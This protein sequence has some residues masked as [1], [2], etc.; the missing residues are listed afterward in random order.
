MSA[1]IDDTTTDFARLLRLVE[2]A[3][4]HAYLKHGG[5]IPREDFRE[6]GLHGLTRALEKTRQPDALGAYAAAFIKGEI[7]H[8]PHRRV[9][10][11][12]REVS[13]WHETH[14]TGRWIPDNPETRLAWLDAQLALHATCIPAHLL[15]IYNAIRA[16]QGMGRGLA[17][18][19]GLSCAALYKRYEQLIIFCRRHLVRKETT[20][21]AGARPCQKSPRTG[22]PGTHTDNYPPG[23]R[24]RCG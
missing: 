23:P 18:Q 2:S 3:A 7:T 5:V 19:W 20:C 22:P 17:R 10:V 4:T 21:Q 1:S 8:L 24:P 14:S 11:F 13:W 16:G 9:V 6:A 15:T 12:N